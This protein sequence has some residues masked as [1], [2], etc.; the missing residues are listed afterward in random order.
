MYVRMVPGTELD[1]TLDG[2][3]RVV[4]CRLKPVAFDSF[5]SFAK[6]SFDAMDNSVGY[7]GLFCL[8]CL[9]NSA[10]ST[11]RLNGQR[12]PVAKRAG[13]GLRKITELLSNFGE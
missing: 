6:G 10:S 1:R 7:R 9:I 3:D 8:L 2:K 5:S 12:V 13:W 11:G 4:G